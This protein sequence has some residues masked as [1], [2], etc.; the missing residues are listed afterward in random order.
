[1]DHVQQMVL[2]LLQQ[3]KG[4]SRNGVGVKINSSLTTQH[5]Y[6]GPKFQNEFGAGVGPNFQ[7]NNGDVI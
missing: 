3:K 5:V 7:V 6:A 1:M 2:L 4:R